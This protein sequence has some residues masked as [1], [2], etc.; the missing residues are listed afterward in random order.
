MF[1]HLGS[2]YFTTVHNGGLFLFVET[3]MT[4]NVKECED[5]LKMCLR[6]ALVRWPFFQIFIFIVQQQ[7]PW[8]G[9][10][11]LQLVAV[12]DTSIFS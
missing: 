8:Y 4:F 10:L 7:K 2:S 12:P 5:T 6:S 1:M 9:R 3:Q 11:Y